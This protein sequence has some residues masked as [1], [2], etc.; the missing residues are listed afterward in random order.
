MAMR[1]SSRGGAFAY[2]YFAQC[3][4]HCRMKTNPPDSAPNPRNNSFAQEREGLQ[5]SVLRA[6][7]H[8]LKT[9]LACIIGS[10]EIYG[11]TKDRLS[12]DK[13]NI[14]IDTALQEAYRLDGLLTNV[15]EMARLEQGAVQVKYQSYDM[16]LLLQDCLIQLGQRL[17]GCDI[18]I[19]G[20]PASFSVTTDP[21]LLTRAICCV[22]DN[23]VIYGQPHP[24]IGVEYE[25]SGEQAVIRIWDNGP[26]IAEFKQ[27][28][29]FTKYTRFTPQ[30][31]THAGSGLGLP[32]CREIMRLL[33]GMVEAANLADGTG[34]VFTL[35]F[36][37]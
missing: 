27:E 23:A 12:P 35:T 32:I 14:L 11:R 8:D 25:K 29:I 20:I 24:V 36:A 26:G 37:S 19:K 33:G 22:L 1:R 28:E 3:A 7:S 17:S 16:D 5:H 9:P 13:Q 10:L 4:T 6:F 2:G 30:G 15:L 18:S 34:A 31:H 21:L